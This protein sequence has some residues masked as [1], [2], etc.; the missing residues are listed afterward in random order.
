[1]NNIENAIRLAEAGDYK[2]AIKEIS[3]VR[4]SSRQSEID[5]YSG[6][7]FRETGQKK[8]ASSYFKKAAASLQDLFSYRAC[9][10]L[11]SIYKQQKTR[12][13]C[14][15]GFDYLEKALAFAE[16]LEATDKKEQ[17]YEEIARYIIDLNLYDDLGQDYLNID[18]LKLRQEMS[19]KEIPEGEKEQTG[20]VWLIIAHL[21]FRHDNNLEKTGE[22][23]DK[24]FEMFETSPEVQRSISK[25]QS[26]VIR[27]TGMSAGK[28]YVPNLRDQDRLRE[29][30]KVLTSVL[31]LDNLLT[32]VVDNV[33]EVAGAERGFLMLAVSASD[34]FITDEQT[35]SFRIA[36]NDKKIALEEQDF[37]ISRSIVNRVI[38]NGE[39]VLLKNLEEVDPDLLTASIVDLQLK[40]LL[41]LP[42]NIGNRLLGVI[43]VDN[44]IARSNFGQ[45]EFELL[46]A[47]S[48]Q[49]AIA[50][51][52]ARLYRNLQEKKNRLESLLNATQEMI[53][54]YDVLPA[55]SIFTSHIL[56]V[57]PPFS[58]SLPRVYLYQKTEQPTCYSWQY[59]NFKPATDIDL[60]PN[61][62]T[63]CKLTFDGE[64][65]WI[66]IWQEQT[67]LGLL[68]LMGVPRKDIRIGDKRFISSLLGSL[69]RILDRVKRDN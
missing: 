67:Q 53:E 27:Q 44:S 7:W 1:M 46:A 48:D 17:T 26:D 40:S 23:T 19:L 57:I 68:V 24:A 29:V 43:Y 8:K 52:N 39:A 54:A 61:I 59:G 18:W 34:Q 50:I 56:K 11:A 4:D 64:S 6:L 5:Y 63:I 51:E 37:A 30:N 38:D 35:L 45:R 31:D 33:I 55:L 28:A 16:H 41:C 21:F 60:P 65:I 10:E 66:P 42:L 9:H 2:Q 3:A 25:F 62:E 58:T 36:R 49:A 15:K 13:N 69:S 14:L 22:Y 32:L 20:L 47:L 12:K